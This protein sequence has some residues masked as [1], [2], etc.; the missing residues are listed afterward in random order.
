MRRLLFTVVLIVMLLG[1]LSAQEAPKPTPIS[2]LARLRAA[3]S[4]FLKYGEGSDFPYRLFES[5][6]TGWGR[7][8]LVDSPQKADIIIEVAAPSDESGISVGSSTSRTSPLGGTSEPPFK[9]NKQFSVQRILLTVYDA[10]SNVRLWFASE[11]PK[12]AMKQKAKE[13][14]IVDATQLLFSKFRDIVEPPPAQ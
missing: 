14:N 12:S 6:L 4:A 13:D 9:T 8:T 3:K 2:P 10:H 11:R 5:S 7:F 1:G